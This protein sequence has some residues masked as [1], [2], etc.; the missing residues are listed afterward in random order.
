MSMDFLN[1]DRRN[2]LNT[3]QEQQHDEDVMDTDG[4]RKP[5]AFDELSALQYDGDCW[6]CRCINNKTL[7]TNDKL[8][9]LFRLYSENCHNLPTN[10]IARQMSQF[11]NRFIRPDTNAEWPLPTILE[12]I[13]S[14]SFFPSSELIGQIKMLRI[15]RD[16]LKNNLVEIDNDGKPHFSQV[17]MKLLITINKE[18][19]TLLESKNK[20]SDM[21]GFSDVLNF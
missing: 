15:L 21:I 4:G 14:H 9:S 20:I 3:I 13:T 7:Q 10:A 11:F 19:R 5:M 1:T 17:N 2:L 16:K 12:H 8:L 18:I 6:A